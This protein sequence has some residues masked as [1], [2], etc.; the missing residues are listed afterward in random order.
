MFAI[1]ETG[2]KQYKVSVND[3]IYAE[4][5]EGKIG[6]KI[7]FDKVLMCGDKIGMPYVQGASVVCEIVKQGKQPKIT[8]IKHISQKHHTKKQGHRQPYTKLVVKE[9]K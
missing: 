7:T 4:K 9:I 1:F 2:G 5:I 3:T 8:I 6:D